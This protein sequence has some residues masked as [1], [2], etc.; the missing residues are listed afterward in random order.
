MLAR[1]R[2]ADRLG[3]PLPAGG[4]LLFTQG[5]ERPF[6]LGEGAIRDHAVGEDLDIGVGVSSGVLG[7]MRMLSRENGVARFMVTVSNDQPRPIEFE[8][9]FDFQITRANPS[10]GQRNGRP[11][12]TVTVPAN[13]RAVLCFSVVPTEDD[14]LPEQ[15]AGPDAACP[16]EAS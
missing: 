10:L 9:E 4:F 3:V 2:V 16:V 8:G 13:G 7:R 1:N 11:L 15:A 6:L 12:W 14:D 5:R